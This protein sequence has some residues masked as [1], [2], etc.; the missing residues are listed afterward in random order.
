MRR[1]QPPLVGATRLGLAIQAFTEKICA[2]YTVPCIISGAGV[3]Y[4]LND[5]TARQAYRIIQQAVVNALQ[6]A[7]PR[8]LRVTIAADEHGWECAVSDDGKGFDPNQPQRNNHF[9]LF[10]MHER[11]RTIGAALTIDSQPGRGTTVRL[12]LKKAL[13]IE[14]ETWDVSRYPVSVENVEG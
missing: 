11:A 14:D 2:L 12:R 6:H 10:S 4:P 8:L 3:A 7:H 9:G 1:L 5:T 13:K